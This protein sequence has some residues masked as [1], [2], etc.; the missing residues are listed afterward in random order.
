ME[1]WWDSVHSILD[2]MDYPGSLKTDFS[3]G[4]DLHWSS[5]GDSVVMGLDEGGT[6]PF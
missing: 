1:E 5:F 6:P 3:L 4:Y 2:E